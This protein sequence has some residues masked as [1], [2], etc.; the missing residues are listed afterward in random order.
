MEEP[1]RGRPTLSLVLPI[2][3][4]Q[5]VI[6]ELHKRLQTFLAKLALPAE[7]VFVDDGSKDESMA[8][9]RGVAAGE[10]RYRILS[11]A[12]NFGHQTAITA[13]VDYARGH[14]VV[15]MDADLQDP[16]EVVL[17]MVSK[18]R[19]GF[20]VV[21]GRRRKREGETWFKL[22]TARIFYR[23]FAAM[24]PIEV[25]LDTGDFRLMGRSVVVALRQLRETHRFVR[26][27]VAW[28]GF[29][30]TEVLYDRPGRFAGE[31]KYP[32]RKM[33]RFALDG[34]TSFSILPL[35]FATYL[36]M[37]TIVASFG[38]VVWALVSK[39]VLHHVVEGWTGQLIVTAVFASVQLLMIGILGEYIGRIYEEVKRRP[40]YVV[41]TT[42]NLRPDD[43]ELDPPPPPG[44]A[45]DAPTVDERKGRS[46]AS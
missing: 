26:G 38:V 45:S 35:R 11:F 7:V 43:D 29:K 18:W 37:V 44:P 3:N 15:V 23:L 25:P 28:V 19:D 10:P 24:I 1:R 4:E 31:T 46:P 36:G 20:D 21:Y 8:L 34:I 6:P 40:L 2:Y 41:G 39:Y 32:L 27:M 14:A 42:V 22:V 9:L 16:P 30:Q 17:E 5:D 12:R 33:V 13:G